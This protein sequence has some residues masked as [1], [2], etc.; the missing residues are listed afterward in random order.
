VVV[1]GDVLSRSQRRVQFDPISCADRILKLIGPDLLSVRF[2]PDTGRLPRDR[3]SSE[4]C[5]PGRPIRQEV[6]VCA[7]DQR[8]VGP[9]QSRD[10]V[11]PRL[12]CL[13]LGSQR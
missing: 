9:L 7:E 8:L 2:A 10:A 6:M 13:Q 5:L 12:C 11:E 3:G 4:L 1:T